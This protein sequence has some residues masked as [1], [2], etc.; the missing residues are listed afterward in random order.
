MT[1]SRQPDRPHAAVDYDVVIVGGGLVGASMAC[2][3]ESADV[4]VAIVERFAPDSAAQPSFDE[5]TIALTWSSRQVFNALGVWD[6]AEADASPIRDIHISDRGHV[7]ECVLSHRDA[8]TD[9]LGY[10]VT[11]RALGLALHERVEN[12]AN[13]TLLCPAE[14]DSVKSHAD[15]ADV[16]VRVQGEDVPRVLTT[17]LLIM[18]DGGRSAVGEQLG[19]VAKRKV[20]TQSALIT[21]V[22]S[23][24][25]HGGRAYERF[26]GSGPLALLPLHESD[27]AVVWTLEPEAVETMRELADDRLLARLQLAFGD[28]A[29]RFTAIGERQLYPLSVTRVSRP[30]APRVVAIGNAAHVVHPVAGQG[31]NLGLKDVADLAEQIC[32]RRLTG[33]DIG[34][35]HALRRYVR[36]RRRETR[37]VR[38]FTDSMIG[39]FASDFPPLVVGRNLGLMAIDRLPPVRRAL[40]ERTM[41]LHGRQPKL[42]SGRPLQATQ[43][44]ARQHYDVVIVGAGLIGAA[45][46]C[47]LGDTR[48]R[49]ALVD[50]APPPSV[51][52]GDFRLRINAYNRA[53]ERMLADCG[54]WDRLPAERV[55]PF[56]RVYCGNA[57]GEGAV[58][59]AATDI[60]ETH[61]GHFVENDLV[62]AI[63]MD[64]VA[65]F[66]NVD[67]M[68]DAELTDVSF[69]REQAVVHLAGRDALAARLLVGSDGA[70]SRVREAAGI[71]VSRHPY[72]QRCIVGTIKF[73]GDLDETAWQR[74]L[75]TGPVGLL[76]LAPGY[77][78]LAWSCD[79]AHAERLLALDDD[80]FRDELHAA[81]RGRLGNITGIGQRASFPLMARDATTYVADRTVLVGDAAHVIHPLAGLGA[82]IG[83]Q[84]IWALSRS[85][86]EVADDPAADIGAPYRLRHYER[87]RHRENRVV[88]STMS[89]FNAVFSNDVYALEKLRNGALSVANL[90]LPAKNL[91]M[92]RAMWMDM[93]PRDSAPQPRA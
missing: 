53:A 72:H 16:H 27:F 93:D 43:A 88:M 42:V 40:L 55:F 30:T 87:S 18:A 32:S 47:L 63:L 67:T 33:D 68:T 36:L 56:R 45:L 48:Y 74:F 73:D 49:V 69:E 20:Y 21:T 19:F 44:A 84:D 38:N 66:D 78:S 61:L 81:I 80:A 71:G 24:R 79:E 52:S 65:E 34:D 35:A 2:A 7:G 90:V 15:R 83:F 76:P 29:G 77:C 14:V 28:Q 54:V 57:G 70:N 59:F 91:L 8:G 17:H 86:L 22:R 3:L 46:A 89:A 41:G 50:R 12:V 9:A 62:T 11:T 13:A 64:R 75:R 10:V 51:P 25:A 31:F 5:R 6:A 1:G 58:R 60:G 4:T 85:L 39:V 92:R 26:V 82:N 37:N 23:D